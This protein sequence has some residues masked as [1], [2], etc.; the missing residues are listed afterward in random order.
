MSAGATF[1]EL[2]VI[3]SHKIME[4]PMLFGEVG[5]VWVWCQGGRCS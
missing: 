5:V 4:E 2:H 3:F 1:Y